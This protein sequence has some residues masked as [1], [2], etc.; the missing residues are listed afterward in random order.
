M[1]S[2]LIIINTMFETFGDRLEKLEDMFAALEDENAPVNIIRD[3]GNLIEICIGF[4]FQN[5]FATLNTIDEK[6]KF[7][8]F[9]KNNIA[10]LTGNIT[11]GVFIGL[12]IKLRREFQN[13]LWLQ[14][15]ISSFLDKS[16]AI[17][18]RYAHANE[19]DDCEMD[20][21][22]ILYYTQKII[23]GFG[24]RK[25]E[26]E[27]LGFGIQQYLVYSGIK[28][29]H[30]RANYKSVIHDSYV[31]IP[32]ITAQFINKTYSNLSVEQKDIIIHA[33]DFPQNNHEQDE[34]ALLKSIFNG[35]AKMNLV[36]V[37][38]KQ[39][40]KFKNTIQKI[41]DRNSVIPR[42]MAINFVSILDILFEHLKNEKYTHFLEYI[43]DV[44]DVYRAGN[45]KLEIEDRSYLKK[46]ATAL[47]IEQSDADRFRV[48]VIETINRI[49]HDFL[50]FAI[51]SELP[52]ELVKR[53]TVANLFNFARMKL[54]DK[55]YDAAIE[56]L[57]EIIRINHDEAF[58]YI[59]RGICHELTENFEEASKD[60]NQADS[61]NN[62]KDY[63]Y[64]N[65]G[66]A[67][68]E[69]QD[70]SGA[71]KEFNVAIDIG[72]SKDA[73]FFYY[74][75]KAKE[76]LGLFKDAII[77]YERAV[78]LNHKHSGAVHRIQKV[79]ERRKNEE[80]HIENTRKIANL[81]KFACAKLRDKEYEKA[82]LDFNQ[83]IELAPNTAFY[84]VYRGVTFRFLNNEKKSS[85]DFEKALQINP[86]K[87]FFHYNYGLAL[88]EAREYDKAVQHFSKAIKEN[89][90]IP[91][92]FYYRGLA[93]EKQKN[94]E[95]ALQNYNNAQQQDPN[96]TEAGRNIEKIR[97]RKTAVKEKLMGVMN[98][99]TFFNSACAKLSD[100][101]YQEAIEDLSKTIELQ[102]NTAFY[103]VYRGVANRY[104]GNKENA[105]KDFEYAQKLNPNTDFFHYNCCRAKMLSKNYSD[106]LQ[107]INKA[108]ELNTE[109]ANYY[110][111]RAKIK[112]QAGRVNDAIEDYN[113]AHKKNPNHP[114]ALRCMAKLREEREEHKREMKNKELQEKRKLYC[115]SKAHEYFENAR[116]YLSI[117]EYNNAIQQLNKA[118]KNASNTAYYFIYRGVAFCKLGNISAMNED[119]KSA[120]RLNTDAAMFHFNKGKAEFDTCNF[121]EAIK[122]I[123]AAIAISRRFVFY[124]YRMSV[125]RKLGKAEET[126]NDQKMAEKLETEEEK[127]EY[128]FDMY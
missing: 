48:L 23:Y 82:I 102:P 79:K 85:A 70:F 16:N 39:H 56:D 74:R 25:L 97:K 108:I 11:I 19:T 91:D 64:Y 100:N 103:Y 104:A 55:K 15:D 101:E 87:H 66:L 78:K 95:K 31:V 9:E 80:R 6:E 26:I 72:K 59:F 69:A 110:F 29:E 36:S 13:H 30:I 65:R 93:Y 61:I 40:T 83:I 71:I 114:E 12:Y 99:E 7:L 84:Y 107:D 68:I 62:N 2:K 125:N 94:Y 22:D 28:E 51:D 41:L 52:D 124:N 127:D 106:A 24:F 27:G 122:E 121:D 119:F 86:K 32:Q 81:F 105:S 4:L 46:K 57:N 3:C 44:K 53:K 49:R 5:F 111:F 75:G 42:S 45:Y 63:Y 123:D 20:A 54:N 120:R 43:N 117:K 112:Q 77:D 34:E 47:R 88:Y 60:F 1:A 116:Y 67:R 113:T 33:F 126:I 96:H 128:N 8:E 14:N 38:G 35:F 90:N 115:H 21:D 98:A 73:D 17:R 10:K 76:Y 109:N 50:S 118:L 58:Y 37:L 18:N 92:Y 89:E